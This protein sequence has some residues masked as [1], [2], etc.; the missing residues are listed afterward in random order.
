MA[1][2]RRDQAFAARRVVCAGAFRVAWLPRAAL[3]AP[4]LVVPLPALA[5]GTLPASPAG[6]AAGSALQARH[7]PELV[8]GVP[9][10]GGGLHELRD[11]SGRTI[12]RH[13]DRQP[14]LARSELR[15]ALDAEQALAAA[16]GWER[17]FVPR[18]PLDPRL[19]RR[20]ILPLAGGIPLWVVHLPPVPGLAYNPV[21]LVHAGSGRVLHAEN[22]VFFARRVR[23]FPGNPLSTPDLIETELPWLD[24]D[25]AGSTLSCP[26]L[27]SFNCPDRHELFD[28]SFMGARGQVHLCSEVQLA[29]A[30]AAGDFLYSPDA[31]N[32]DP[33]DLFAEAHMF[34]HATRVYRHFQELGFDRLR[35]VPLRAVVNF[36]IPNLLE[37]FSPDGELEPFDNAFFLPA[38]DLRDIIERDE[39]SIVFGQ[40]TRVDF[41]YDADVIYHEFSHAVVDTAAGLMMATLDRWGVSLLPGGL[42]EGYADFF[43]GTL[44]G[45][46]QIGEY[47]GSG[48]SEEGGA[49]R[50]IAGDAVFPL[51]QIGEVHEDSLPW[52]GA[53]WELRGELTAGGVAGVDFDRAVLDALAALPPD[54]DFATAAEATLAAL[55][56]ALGGEAAALGRQVM[57]RRGVT[58]AA[59]VMQTTRKELLLLPG[60]SSWNLAN[61]VPG[62]FQFQV[63]VE[64]AHGRVVVEFLLPEAG[65]SIPG[66]G[67][68]P[69][70][71]ITM[72]RAGEKPIE[73]EYASDGANLRAVP[74]VDRMAVTEDLD[75]NRPT[76]PHR[77]RAVLAFRPGQHV[78]HVMIGNRGEGE[79]FLRQITL[80]PEEDP[81]NPWVPLPD[82]GLPEDAG[83]EDAGQPADASEPADVSE[84][85]GDQGP[86]EVDGGVGPDAAALDAGKS[87]SGVRSED[88]DGGCDC[89][90]LPHA[91]AP[92]ATGWGLL[93]LLLALT[94]Q[95][96]WRRAGG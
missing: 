85:A 60:K 65:P 2:I 69:A 23:V 54:A 45:D 72:V 17:G 82:A 71:P 63:P 31:T 55:G 20:A 4:L 95:R 58:T 34:Y 56:E 22:R 94:V 77:L 19:A 18:G 80:T 75:A 3:L 43:C 21:L 64:P 12:W 39:D 36:R 41:A 14:A 48:F 8:Q 87:G 30:D 1:L 5:A 62:A 6:R 59:R 10:L 88:E 29:Q 68:G 37:A 86:G 51:D 11:S 91:A 79:V 57:E 33:E 92:T 26:L 76:W 13:D 66:F 25:A 42:H 74:R 84:P 44:G 73:V 49:I 52:S 78:V 9:V 40:G 16:L 93:V 35:Q 67:G 89:A 38:G 32:I 7:V 24:G 27:R 15:W 28:V 53:L 70:E 96:R 81:D 61:F 50:D 47:A 90:A 83:P 46:P